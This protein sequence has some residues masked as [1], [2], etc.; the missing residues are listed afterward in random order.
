M[1]SLF[2]HYSAKS[3]T[4]KHLAFTGI[5]RESNVTYNRV[6]PEY[7]HAIQL[8]SIKLQQIFIKSNKHIA[9]KCHQAIP[10]ESTSK[11]IRSCHKPVL[12]GDSREGSLV[13][14]V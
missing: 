6:F 7:Q 9:R 5:I 10:I 14:D 8:D 13:D 1:A 12:R 11:T 4:D 2:K 3:I